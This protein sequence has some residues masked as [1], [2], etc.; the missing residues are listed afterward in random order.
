MTEKLLVWDV[1][2]QNKQIK[3]QGK[4]EGISIYVSVDTFI[5]RAIDGDKEV[6]SNCNGIHVSTFHYKHVPDLLQSK[7]DSKDQ[8]S[9][10]SSTTP[11]PGYQ[12]GK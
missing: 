9:I 3:V 12:M 5:F 11:V 8:V 7:K 6:D 2:N 1:K 10:Q 4:V